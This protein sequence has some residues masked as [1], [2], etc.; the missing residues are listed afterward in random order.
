[1]LFLTIEK[2]PTVRRVSLGYS[3]NFVHRLLLQSVRNFIAELA[4]FRRVR[5]VVTSLR[6]LRTLRTL[7]NLASSAIKLRML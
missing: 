3:F 2:S 6:T 1:M 5:R 4:K 7:R